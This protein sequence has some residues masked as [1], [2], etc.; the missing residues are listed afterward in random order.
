MQTQAETDADR[1]K[2]LSAKA[3]YLKAANRKLAD[4]KRV[5]AGVNAKIRN[6]VSIGRID[7]TERFKRAQHAVDLMFLSAEQRIEELRKADEHSWEACADD[8][9][10]A[11]EDLSQSVKKLVA[12]F[13]DM[14]K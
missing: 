13:S 3:A 10:S 7:P 11:W 1:V 14:A 9:D 12:R 2:T 4:T 8:V 5:L 6:A